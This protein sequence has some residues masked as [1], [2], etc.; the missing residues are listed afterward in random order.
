M[1]NKMPKPKLNFFDRLICKTR[2]Y[3]EMEEYYSAQLREL[4]KDQNR[5]IFGSDDELDFPN[6]RKEE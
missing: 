4:R 6:S 5:L 2:A 3:R 1:K